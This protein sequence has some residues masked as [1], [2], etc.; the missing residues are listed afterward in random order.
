[1]AV[2]TFEDM[3]TIERESYTLNIIQILRQR[4]AA[5]TKMISFIQKCF[6]L[7]FILFFKLNQWFDQVLNQI[8]VDFNSKKK[9][10]D[11]ASRNLK[12]ERIRLL[13]DKI[14]EKTGEDVVLNLMGNYSNFVL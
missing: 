8:L 3:K 4:C 2:N 13:Q 1:M 6:N 12:C 11:D 5:V 14:K 10:Y 9:E 7:S